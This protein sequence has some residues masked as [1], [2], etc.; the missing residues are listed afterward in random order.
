MNTNCDF[1]CNFQIQKPALYCF[2]ESSITLRGQAELTSIPSLK[3]WINDSG[4]TSFNIL[5]YELT[6][7]QNCV[8][9]ITSLDEVGCGSGIGNT[10]AISKPLPIAS[11][12]AGVAAGVALLLIIVAIA[13]IFVLL[14]RMKRKTIIR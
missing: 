12:A 4:N 13:V 1:H 3:K 2:D 8:V 11:V 7:D 9:I 14:R 5:G 6:V 10:D